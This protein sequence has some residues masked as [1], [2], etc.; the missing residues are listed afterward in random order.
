MEAKDHYQ[1]SRE[2][3][4]RKEKKARSAEKKPTGSFRGVYDPALDPDQARP[5]DEEKLPKVKGE[6]GQEMKGSN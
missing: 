3:S 5:Q 6:K 4:R 1:N 2:T